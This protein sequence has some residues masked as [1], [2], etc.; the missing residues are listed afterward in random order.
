MYPLDLL[1]QI[2]LHLHVHLHNPINKIPLLVALQ[3]QKHRHLYNLLYRLLIQHL[4]FISAR[5]LLALN[6]NQVFLKSRQVGR[7]LKAEVIETHKVVRVDVLEEVVNK[8]GC[9]ERLEVV[10]GVVAAQKSTLFVDPR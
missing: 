5:Q 9:F 10:K 4:L 3:Q 6:L 1:H 8:T 2:G 7:H